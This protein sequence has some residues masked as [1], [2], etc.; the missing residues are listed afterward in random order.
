MY[1]IK[2]YLLCICVF[3]REM[4]SHCDTLQL[5]EQACLQWNLDTPP[6]GGGG[7]IMMN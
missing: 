3:V 4:P 6:G 1:R 5:N 2:E 7:G